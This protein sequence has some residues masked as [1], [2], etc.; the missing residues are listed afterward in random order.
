MRPSGEQIKD[1]GNVIEVPDKAI[2]GVTDRL[3]LEVHTTPIT[4]KQIGDDV[5]LFSGESVSPLVH[6]D[7]RLAPMIVSLEKLHRKIYEKACKDGISV[8]FAD[9]HISPDTVAFEKRRTFL[10][11][12]GGGAS[13]LG[14]QASFLPNSARYAAVAAVAWLMGPRIVRNTMALW[15]GDEITDFRTTYGKTWKG[16]NKVQNALHPDETRFTITLR[17][18]LIS[19]K[20]RAAT[21]IAQG[22]VKKKDIPQPKNAVLSVGDGHNE[23]SELLHTKSDDELLE[24]IRKELLQLKNV[25]PDNDEMWSSISHFPEVWFSEKGKDG[26]AQA[27]FPLTAE[28]QGDHGMNFICSRIHEDRRLA[29]LVREIRGR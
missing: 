1:P 24:T 8:Y 6:T 27:I 12:L 13:A 2:E 20:H 26:R 5:L 14:T 28:L 25:D 7:P 10:K 29:E 17:N 22:Q 4:E 15:S 21:R 9:M 3:I 23:I 11:V 19:Y 18:A 16:V